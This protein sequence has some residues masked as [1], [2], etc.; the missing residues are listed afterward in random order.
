MAVTGPLLQLQQMRFCR[1]PCC[2]PCPVN[3]PE[4]A[5][6]CGYTFG[7]LHFGNHLQMPDSVDTAL[8]I[9]PL[10]TA[11]TLVSLLFDK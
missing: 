5:C 7:N 4:N 1:Q 3:H 9:L 11:Q 2:Q 6:F 10:D 8:D